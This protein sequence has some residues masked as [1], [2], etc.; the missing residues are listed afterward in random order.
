M[1]WNAD[2]TK[3]P[4]LYVYVCHSACVHGRVLPTLSPVCRMA[5]AVRKS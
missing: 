2:E 4:Y 1:L 3:C 5:T